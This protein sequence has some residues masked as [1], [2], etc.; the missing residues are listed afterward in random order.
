MRKFIFLF[1]LLFLFWFSFAAQERIVTSKYDVIKVTLDWKH[2]I[3]VNA[4]NNG[5][6]A[7]SLKTL[8]DEVGWVSAIN[9]WFFC[10]KE[11]S[12]SRCQQWYSDMMAIV[13]WNLRS[14]YWEDIGSDRAL[15]WFTS[16]WLPMLVTRASDTWNWSQRIN[17][18][19]KNIEYWISMYVLLN[20]WVDVSSS[21]SMTSDSKQKL[22]WDKL[23]ICST[24]DKKHVYMWKIKAVTFVWL[25]NFIEKEFWCYDAIQ[26]DWGGSRAMIYNNSYI[27]WPGRSVMDA[28][29]VVEDNSE[30][31]SELQSAITWMYYNWMTQYNDPESFM[32]KD[33]INREQA[34]KIFGVFAWKFY[35]KE[36]NSG[37]LCDF[38]DL[39]QAE[40]SLQWNIVSAC[41][42][43]LFQ[44]YEWKFDPKQNLTNS[45][46]LAVISRIVNDKLD[47][48]I[49]PWY[50]N[51]YWT[52]NLWKFVDAN[53]LNVWD[54]FF[55]EDNA[56]RWEIAIMLY[57]TYNK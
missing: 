50:Q 53:W 46:A 30:Y 34:S 14:M 47:E 29:I 38:S 33:P 7:K 40:V 51:Y 1:W 11:K 16:E 22:A 39:S 27:L 12:Y 2:K 54:I 48:S 3:I 6:D 8:M 31:L 56:T 26:L 25:A 57:R 45:Q 52:N 42:M 28:F 21:S 24:K 5:D 18:L 43:W 23:F 10:P 13:N 55:A 44:W 15:F 9:W 36:I 41:M 19:L 37:N 49:I 17:L 32:A 35:S 4:V 20:W